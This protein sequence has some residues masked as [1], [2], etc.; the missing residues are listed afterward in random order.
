MDKGP[1]LASAV[2]LMNPLPQSW[3]GRP[4]SPP[5]PPGWATI[6][7][8]SASNVRGLLSQIAYNQSLWNYQ[9]IGTNNLLGRY[10][11]N[12]QLL[13]SYGLL[14]T[15]SNTAYG[16]DCVNYLHCWVPLYYN[17]NNVNAYQNYFY[18][19]NSLSEFL[20]NHLAQE[21]LAYQR[22]SD[23]Y[24][25]CINGGILQDS[26]PVDMAAGMV[27]VA[28]TLGVGSSPSP[29]Y[30]SGTGAWAWRFNGLGDGID[31]FNSGRYAITVLS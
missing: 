21:H 29:G 16:T 9:L 23:L 17:T 20:N 18:N 12:S 6:G 10:Q 30:P 31:S 22:I 4:D 8:F 28:W 7:L 11:F 25:N 5:T 24:I 2:P 27:S 1:L 14:A 19:I 13:E 15:G 26:D 3:I